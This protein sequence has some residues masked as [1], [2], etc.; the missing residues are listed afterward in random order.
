[1]IHGQLSLVKLLFIHLDRV[2]QLLPSSTDSYSC[3][4]VPGK[5][6]KE[7]L[8][9]KKQ[10][11]QRTGKRTSSPRKNNSFSITRSGRTACFARYLV[12]SPLAVVGSSVISRTSGERC[13]VLYCPIVLGFTPTSASNGK[14]PP[15]SGILEQST[16][17]SRRHRLEKGKFPLRQTFALGHH[18]ALSS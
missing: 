12:L 13:L 10:K 15:C 1:M 18:L 17:K 9:R 7:K 5:M 4:L 11:A 8:H 6:N 16:C 3:L 14:V 2:F